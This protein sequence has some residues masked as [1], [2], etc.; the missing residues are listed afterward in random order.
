MY[1]IPLS[2]APE[3]PSLIFAPAAN[4]WLDNIW[5]GFKISSLGYVR[6][7]ESFRMELPSQSIVPGLITQQMTIVDVRLVEKFSQCRMK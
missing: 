7:P 5:P 6:T 1:P 2:L 3:V 4:A